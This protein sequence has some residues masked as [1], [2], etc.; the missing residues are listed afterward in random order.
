MLQKYDDAIKHLTKAL[1]IA[2]SYYDA[3][4]KMVVALLATNR[5]D[6][7]VVYLNELL[8]Q[9]KD[10]AE[11]NYNLAVALSVQNKNDEAIKYLSRALEINPNYSYAHYRMGIILL[12]AGKPNEAIKYLNKAL[13]TNIDQGDVYENLGVAYMQLDKNEPAKQNLARAVELEP[14]NINTLNNLA[15]LLA[16]AGDASAQDAN[17]AVEFA[18]RACELTG[19]K[20][21]DLMDTLAVA[22]AAAGRFEDAVK[23]ANKAIDIARAG[24]QED[25]ANEIQSRMKLY[26]AGQPYREK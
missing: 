26:Q 12:A 9:N 2:P 24:N 1:E 5:F 7:A 22:Y 11:A 10:S 25:L 17:R 3:R 14:N 23:T 16:T 13:Q 15:W 21:P 8:R 19:Y 4:N 20:K 18:R 6:E